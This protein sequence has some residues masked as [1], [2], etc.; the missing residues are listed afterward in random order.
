MIDSRSRRR[1]ALLGLIAWAVTGAC[2]RWVPLDPIPVRSSPSSQ[3][4]RLTT[5]DGQVTELEGRLEVTADS[6][7]L[8]PARDSDGFGEP[9]RLAV[10]KSTIE[11][12]EERSPNP[13]GTVLL[14]GGSILAAGAIYATV[15][16]IAVLPAD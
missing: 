2:H 4:W 16:L 7:I 1:L 10:P 14:V 11:R 9:E 12:L 15:L 3:R 8:D 13:G 6:L 5:V